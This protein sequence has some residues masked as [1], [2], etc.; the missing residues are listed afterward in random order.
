M[1]IKFYAR[2]KKFF[3]TAIFQPFLS[4]ARARQK[5]DQL[6]I[7]K[8]KNQQQMQHQHK[9]QDRHNNQITIVT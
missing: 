9:M 8:K 3:M 2:Y 1:V 6:M 4:L 7:K 5:K